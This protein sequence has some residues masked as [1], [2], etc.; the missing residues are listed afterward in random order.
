MAVPGSNWT[1][2]ISWVNSGEAGVDT[3]VFF[4]GPYGSPPASGTLP[5]VGAAG[6]G[7]SSLTITMGTSPTMGT[8]YTQVAH[9]KAG[10]SMSALS[11]VTPLGVDSLP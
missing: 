4:G 11:P 5:S 8:Y 3:E 7:K 9:T 6:V 10:Y 2:T 1:A